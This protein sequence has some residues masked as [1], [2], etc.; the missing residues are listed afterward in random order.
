MGPVHGGS[1]GHAEGQVLQPHAMAGVAIA[2]GGLVE[3]QLGARHA[4]RA[5]VELMLVRG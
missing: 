3:E 4:S 5:V 1:T 2:V